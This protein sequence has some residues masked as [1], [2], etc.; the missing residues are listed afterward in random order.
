MS[1]T[2]L[3]RAVLVG[4]LAA[5]LLPLAGCGAG[6]PVPAGDHSPAGDRAGPAGAA[7]ASASGWGSVPKGPAAGAAGLSPPAAT[8]PQAPPP[9][10]APPAPSFPTTARGYAEAAV[11]AWSTGDL[12]RLGEL[13]TAGVHE[14]FVE[15]PG[16]LKADWIH[17]RCD[18]A[19]G[20]SYCTLRNGDGDSLTLR[21][22]NQYLGGPHAVVALTASL[23]TY[24]ADGEAYAGELVHAWAAGNTPRMRALARPDVVVAVN[25]NHQ[26]RP[27]GTWQLSTV[28]EHGG[29]GLLIVHV[30]VNEGDVQ[31]TLHVGTTLL[32]APRAVVGYQP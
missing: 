23:T 18:G 10:P 8:P 17:H 11:A 2:S 24:P 28:S 9:K 13:T 31:L 27:Q 15:I 1:S 21:V 12:A 19:A 26:D 16:T 22:T 32:G 5:A 30:D 29:A 7:P 6:Q 20:S 25:D 14:Q 4:V 3:S